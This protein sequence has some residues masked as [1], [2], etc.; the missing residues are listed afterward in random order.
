[1]PA[2]VTAWESGGAHGGKAAAEDA[3][4]TQEKLR[5]VQ[6][7]VED[8]DGD[9]RDSLLP[10]QPVMHRWQA[11][12]LRALAREKLDLIPPSLR[13]APL[14]PSNGGIGDGWDSSITAELPGP[15][16]GATT[17][18][19]SPAVCFPVAVAVVAANARKGKVTMGAVS[20]PACSSP[21][22]RAT[23][24]TMAAAAAPVLTVGGAASV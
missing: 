14:G 22:A 8:E 3:S 18:G 21:V 23:H 17:L 9:C 4:D 5:A 20:V 11:E 7:E 10:P 1:M 12:S 15:P 24:V 19:L 16:P 6:E 2:V 13:H